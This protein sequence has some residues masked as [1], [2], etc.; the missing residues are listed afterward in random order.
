MTVLYTCFV[1]FKMHKAGLEPLI[2]PYTC[3]TNSGV[4]LMMQ[5]TV[6]FTT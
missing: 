5:K 2:Q 4:N 1:T 3:M 6:W